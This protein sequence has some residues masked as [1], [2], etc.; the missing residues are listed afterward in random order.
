MREA[1]ASA[2]PIAEVAYLALPW[3]MP[4]RPRGGAVDDKP[5]IR[6]DVSAQASSDTRFLVFSQ[7]SPCLFNDLW[8]VAQAHRSVEVPL[9]ALMVTEN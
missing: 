7:G 6:S 9:G 1:H 8:I 3:A 4:V 2:D 5:L